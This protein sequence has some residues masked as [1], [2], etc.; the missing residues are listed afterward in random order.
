MEGSGGQHPGRDGEADF[1]L[2]E[3]VS[4]AQTGD[5]AAL[6]KVVGEIQ[7]QVYRLA[8]QMLWHPEDAEDATQEILIRIIT[9]LGSFKGESAFTTWVYRVACNYLLTTRRRRAEREEISFKQFGQDLD[10]GLSEGP[11]ENH[12]G[13]EKALLVQEVK[14][15][16][17]QGMLLCLDRDQRLTYILGEILDINGVEAG[18]ILGIAPTVFRKRLSRARS[19]LYEFMRSKCGLVDSDRPCRCRK[20]VDR[21]VDLGRVDPERLLFSLHPVQEVS[22]AQAQAG[23]EEVEALRSA[24]SVFRTNPVYAS[25]TDFAQAVR[26]LIKGEEREASNTL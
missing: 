6:E 21:A 18:G 10:Q 24:V 7:D 11:I 2:S 23:L 20:R 22:K 9:R 25:P 13:V 3:Q 17:S 4:R 5:R 15:G 26:Q 14:V 1:S 19:R 8:V 12:G 16:C